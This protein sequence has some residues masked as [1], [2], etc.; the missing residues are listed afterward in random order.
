MILQLSA[1]VSERLASEK[2]QRQM[3]R[4]GGRGVQSEPFSRRFSQV[5]KKLFPHFSSFIRLSPAFAFL[6]DYYFSK[7]LFCVKILKDSAVTAAL[8]TVRAGRMLRPVMASILTD[9]NEKKRAFIAGI[10]TTAVMFAKVAL[11]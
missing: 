11:G 10:I 6:T 1:G 2:R 3:N 8:R 9:R 5:N 4:R 7:S